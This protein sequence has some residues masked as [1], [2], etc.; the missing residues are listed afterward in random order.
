MKKSA[1]ASAFSNL[2]HASRQ[3]PTISMRVSNSTPFDQE[4]EVGELDGRV[5][6]QALV[7]RS[8]A[9]RM[10]TLTR[11]GSSSSA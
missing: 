5:R 2:G 8:T 11:C 1:V 7:G 4:W 6:D 10:S 3:T 9:L